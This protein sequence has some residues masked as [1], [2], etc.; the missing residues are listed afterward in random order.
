[1][2]IYLTHNNVIPRIVCNCASIWLF[3]H[4]DGR[5]GLLITAFLI[6]NIP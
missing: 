4:R 1:M 3:S 5:N 6:S 2:Y